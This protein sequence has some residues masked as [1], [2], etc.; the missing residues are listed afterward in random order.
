MRVVGRAGEL[1]DPS[2]LDRPPLGEEFL[3]DE[4]LDHHR[5]TDAAH[6]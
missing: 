4:I 1:V 2:L 6:V 5:I 3:A